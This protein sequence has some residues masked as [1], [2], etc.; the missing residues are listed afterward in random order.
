MGTKYLPDLE[1]RSYEDGDRP[2][3]S[4]QQDAFKR[5]KLDVKIVK[6]A[7]EAKTKYDLFDRL[8]SGGATLSDQEFRSS[9]IVMTDPSFLDWLEELRS[10]PGF[11]AFGRAER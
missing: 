2:L 5:S 10:A 11:P 7:A 9:L 3:D 4:G 8:N 1:A 6:E